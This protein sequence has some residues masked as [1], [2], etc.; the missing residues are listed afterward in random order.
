MF[1]K[2]TVLIF[3]AILLVTVNLILLTINA[4]RPTVGGLGRAVMVFAAPFQELSTRA[5]IAAQDLWRDYFFLVGVA[6]ENRKLK[7]S[8]EDLKAR[9]SQQR[10]LEHENA[11]LRDLL[12][13]KQALAFPVVAAEIIGKDPS[14]W[15]KTVVINKGSADG[16]QRG[17][18]AVTA[19]GI[20]G[21]I[22]ELSSRQSKLMLIIDSNSAVDALV[23]RTRARGIVKGASQADCYL[24]Y[25]LHEED[26]QVGDTV[27]ASGFDG[28][29][30]KGLMLGTVTAVNVQ[31]VDFFKDVQVRPAV[32]F[33]KLEDVLVVLKKESRMPMDGR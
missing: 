5:V 33:D 10:E 27:V 18:P 29:Y 15:Y 31:G 28:V 17:Q 21:Q 26:V 8:L 6:E 32:N 24:D 16:L 12:G 4:R 7:A 14:I 1:S 25:V 20:A 11:R 9:S 23:Q 13:F 2:K 30:P 22:V 3:S 19:Q